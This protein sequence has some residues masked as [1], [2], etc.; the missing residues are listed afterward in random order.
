M[1]WAYI[2]K[3]QNTEG[4]FKKIFLI[5]NSAKHEFGKIIKYPKKIV[6]NLKKVFLGTTFPPPPLNSME[7]INFGFWWGPPGFFHGSKKA[8]QNSPPPKVSGEKKDF[9]GGGFGKKRNSRRPPT[10]FFLWKCC[11]FFSPPK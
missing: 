5:E 10:F 11:F 6:K 8:P 2:L 7:K 1:F 4:A 3:K 9:R